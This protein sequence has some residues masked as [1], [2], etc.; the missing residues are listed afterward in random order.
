MAWATG[1]MLGGVFAPRAAAAGRRFPPRAAAGR[2]DPLSAAARCPDPLKGGGP[3]V[4]APEPAAGPD[5]G[6]GG[7]HEHLDA[8]RCG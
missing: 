2:R 4:V 8:G 3:A 5:D 1:L 6:N 7:A